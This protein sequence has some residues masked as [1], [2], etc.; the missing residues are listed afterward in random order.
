MK[1]RNGFT[2]IE[3]LVV[4][5]IIALLLSIL[6]PSLQKAKE[7][8]KKVVC[9]NNFKQIGL[10]LALYGAS[11]NDYAA[12]KSGQFTSQP[13][14]SAIASSFSTGKDD[15]GKKY[16]ECPSDNKFR[17]IGNWGPP[18]FDAWFGF[19]ASESSVLPRSYCINAS[20]RNG[21][22][23]IQHGFGTGPNDPYERMPAKYTQVFRPNK[24]IHVVEF[25]LGSNN[26]FVRSSAAP[27][28]NLQG[29]NAWQEALK[30]PIPAIVISGQIDQEGAQHKNGGNWLFVDGHVQWHKFR[31]D[32]VD[33]NTDQLYEGLEYPYNWQWLKKKRANN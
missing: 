25:Q 2:L 29:S 18:G 13:W 11:Y 28:G 20:V 19:A 27:F 33:F 5:S 14:D 10:A 9:A 12:A 3:L 1:K 32:A 17:D 15:A 7:Q 4:I 24:T 26:P 30:S 21:I 23:A 31:K 8:A 16:L 6:L 22:V